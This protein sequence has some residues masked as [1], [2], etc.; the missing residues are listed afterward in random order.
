LFHN[1]TAQRLTLLKQEFPL[2]MRA[3]QKYVG[4]THAMV[5]LR[6]IYCHDLECCQNA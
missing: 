4:K 6:S 3:V 5:G 2:L 1:E